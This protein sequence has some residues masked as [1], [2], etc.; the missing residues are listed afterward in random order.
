LAAEAA[1]MD[2]GW[3]KGKLEHRT[4]VL[5]GREH[6]EASH[7]EVQKIHRVAQHY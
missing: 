7:E 1:R 6:E 5:A 3:E 2:H 4:R